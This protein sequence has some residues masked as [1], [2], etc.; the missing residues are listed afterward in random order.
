MK[1]YVYYVDPD[2]L[3]RLFSCIAI[4]L[5]LKLTDQSFS[6][7]NVFTDVVSDVLFYTLPGDINRLNFFSYVLLSGCALWIYNAKLA[8]LERHIE[9]KKFAAGDIF[10]YQWKNSWNKNDMIRFFV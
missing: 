8:F 5:L 2:M 7:L 6:F 9:I 4:K 10:K 3:V 1:Y